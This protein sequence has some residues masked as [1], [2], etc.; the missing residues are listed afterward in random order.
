MIATEIVR[1]FVG[2][3]GVAL[4][5]PIATYFGAYWLKNKK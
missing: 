2:S 5:M 4:S 1:T 3:I